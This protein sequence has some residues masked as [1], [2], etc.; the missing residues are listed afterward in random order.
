M[1]EAR[2]LDGLD[3]KE[4]EKEVVLEAHRGHF[5]DLS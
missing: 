3:P 5:V 1:V 2:V 4:R